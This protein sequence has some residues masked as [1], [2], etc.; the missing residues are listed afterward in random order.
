MPTPSKPFAAVPHDLLADRRLTPT[1]K[2]IAATLLYWS[3]AKAACWPSNAAIAERANVTSRSVPRSLDRLEELGYVRR[4]KDMSKP[5]QRV[6][7]IAWLQDSTT[8]A[9][10]GGMTPGSWG[11]DPT[12]TPGMTPG[13]SE[14]EPIK[15]KACRPIHGVEDGIEAPPD[16]PALDE[17]E[18]SSD[19]VPPDPDLPFEPAR[20][21][22][23]DRLAVSDGFRGLATRR[24]LDGM[25]PEENRALSEQD[26]HASCLELPLAG[27]RRFLAW[28]REGIEQALTEASR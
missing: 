21:D 18:A 26:A 6:I 4:A 3:Q 15:K 17:C 22:P 5:S 9:D 12:V 7:V 28:A 13:S 10:S 16:D 20:L 1:D 24:R 27:Q 19:W 8:E 2:V 25:A 23:S 11:D 14:L